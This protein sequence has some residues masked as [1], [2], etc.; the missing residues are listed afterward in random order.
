MNRNL[1]DLTVC[2]K[3]LKTTPLKMIEKMEREKLKVLDRSEFEDLRRR[4]KDK[5]VLLEVEILFFTGARI[6][7]ALLLKGIDIAKRKYRDFEF[8][9]FE[10]TTLKK[11]RRFK[12]SIPVIAD[13]LSISTRERL[14][15]LK[16]NEFLFQSIYKREKPMTRQAIYHHLKG[17]NERFYPHLFRHSR[18]SDLAT[19]M[20]LFELAQFAGWLLK[21]VF[22][23][24]AI[25]YY[26]FKNWPAL[27][28]KIIQKK[29]V[30]GYG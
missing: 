24:K 15:L 10:I 6:S 22:R 29:E 21:T 2:D 8:Y 28:D 19:V 14:D 9:I 17:L 30:M 26:I 1:E 16:E 18:L 20:N 11:K 27:A 25:N 13:E 4:I 12:R 5:F 7:E 3:K 23:H